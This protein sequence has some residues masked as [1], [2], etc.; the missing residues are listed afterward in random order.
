MY[1]TGG[2]RMSEL[3]QLTECRGIPLDRW[4]DRLDL[5][6]HCSWQ[7]EESD[8]FCQSCREHGTEVPA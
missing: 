7:R 6:F 8:C 5:L 1:V 2:F 4:L 3:M